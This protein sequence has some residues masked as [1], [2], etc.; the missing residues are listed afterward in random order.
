MFVLS[1]PPMCP[2][3][4]REALAEVMF[5]TFGAAGIY[6]GVQAVLALLAGQAVG[7][8]RS[9]Q[10]VGGGTGCSR[11]AGVYVG[12]QAVR[13]C[14][15]ARLLGGR[16]AHSRWVGVQVH[17]HAQVGTCGIP[18]L[19]TLDTSPGTLGP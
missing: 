19:H 15:L 11:G 17:V 10:Q 5:E 13:R 7:G 9:T 2:P 1:E 16:T 3:E 14:L 6:V 18:A 8:A 4:A 12:V